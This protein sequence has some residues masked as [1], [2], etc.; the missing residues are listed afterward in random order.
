VLIFPLNDNHNLDF[1]LGPDLIRY[2]TIR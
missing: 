1:G 2:D